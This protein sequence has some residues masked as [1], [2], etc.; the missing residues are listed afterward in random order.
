MINGKSLRPLFTHYHACGTT[1]ELITDHPLYR[2]LGPDPKRRQ[3]LYRELCEHKVPKKVVRR[4]RNS[5]AYDYP[6][7][8]ERFRQGIER[9]LG[10]RVGQDHRGRPRRADRPR[11]LPEE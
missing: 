5:I 8:R 7:G 3:Q 9:A 4:I 10:R 11:A 6:L 2:A 1:D